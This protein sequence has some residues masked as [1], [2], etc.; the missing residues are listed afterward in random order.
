[1]RRE[2]SDGHVPCGSGVLGE[3]ADEVVLTENAEQTPSVVNTSE[4]IFFSVILWAASPTVISSL[5][6][7]TWFRLRRRIELTFIAH[8]LTDSGLRAAGWGVR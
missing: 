8:L 4:P 6:V 5:A 2:I 3:R 7:S 1:M